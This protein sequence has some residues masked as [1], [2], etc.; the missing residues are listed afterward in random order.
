M[1]TNF[2][3]KESEFREDERQ[4]LVKEFER[5]L[6][7]GLISPTEFDLLIS[8]NDRGFQTSVSIEPIGSAQH[9]GFD[10]QISITK[11]RILR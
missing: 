7:E 1:C 3:F 8:A 2:S 4:R 9:P 10:L 11:R 6:N 5:I